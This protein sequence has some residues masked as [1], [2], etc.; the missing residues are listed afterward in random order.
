M[1]RRLVNKEM[2]KVG[3]RVLI[4]LYLTG[5]AGEVGKVSVVPGS[6]ARTRI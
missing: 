2:G 4:S 6:R 3:V 5:Y 1:A